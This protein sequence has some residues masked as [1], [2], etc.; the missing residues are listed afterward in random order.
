[1]RAAPAPA[2]L[3]RRA[4]VGALR[5]APRLLLE[6]PAHEQPEPEPDERD[7]DDPTDELGGHELPSEKDP[8]HDPELEDEV[9]RRELERHPGSEARALLEHRLRDRDRGVAARR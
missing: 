6:P 9:S 8:E 3:L 5:V 4:R 7:Q 1:A 2:A